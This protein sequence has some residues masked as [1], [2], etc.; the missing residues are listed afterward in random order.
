MSKLPYLER[1]EPGLER[2]SAVVV[3]NLLFFVVANPGRVADVNRAKPDVPEGNK[4]ATQSGHEGKTKMAWGNQEGEGFPIDFTEL[5]FPRA[6]LQSQ[7]VSV[8]SPLYATR[9]NVP[10]CE[11]WPG[12][13]EVRRHRGNRDRE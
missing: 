3:R 13:V 7:I 12:R 6:V 1:G 9:I 2:P 4:A 5:Q 11:L 8:L 10:F